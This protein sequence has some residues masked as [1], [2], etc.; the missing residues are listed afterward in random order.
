MPSLRRFV[1]LHTTGKYAGLMQILGES[2]GV[3]QNHELPVRLL[4]VALI[5]GRSATAE[6]ARA[7]DRYILYAEVDP[8]VDSGVPDGGPV[9]VPD[10]PADPQYSNPATPPDT[11]ESAKYPESWMPF[12]GGPE[13]LDSPLNLP[14]PD[15]SN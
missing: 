1:L 7:M 12:I 3:L 14:A 11:P 4:G 15:D 5:D 6:L 9:S 2:P 10:T 13:C 8:N